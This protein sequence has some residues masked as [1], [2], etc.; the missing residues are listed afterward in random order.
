MK[1]ARSRY[2]YGAAFTRRFERILNGNK[3]GRQK[4]VRRDVKI[5]ARFSELGGGLYR[6]VPDVG[7]TGRVHYADHVAQSAETFAPQR[8]FAGSHHDHS[9]AHIGRVPGQHLRA[10]ARNAG[11][12]V[13]AQFV[14]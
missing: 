6:N 14:R 9:R 1:Y 13:P 11:I 4:R 7:H 3:N 8:R 5:L 10:A 12:R 2:N